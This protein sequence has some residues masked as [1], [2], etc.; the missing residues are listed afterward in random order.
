[1]IKRCKGFTMIELIM[2]MVIIGILSASV[3]SR[4]NFASHDAAGYAEVI[5]SSIRMAQKLAIAQRD[6][7]IAV[8][9]PVNPCGGV[10]VTGEQCD[11]LPNGV[12]VTNFNIVFD[13][14]GRP[15]LVATAIITVSG[16]E[17]NRFICVEPETGYVGAEAAC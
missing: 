13:G 2:V 4:L 15:N 3:I 6:I 16:G 7:P 1:M 10:Q 14:L 17:V 5:K 8:T 9:F 11:P 12:A